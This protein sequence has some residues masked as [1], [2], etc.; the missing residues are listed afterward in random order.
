MTNLG[1]VFFMNPAEVAASKLLPGPLADFATAAVSGFTGV[2]PVYHLATVKWDRVLV[3]LL[4]VLFLA[5]MITYSV[6][7][8]KADDGYVTGA[9]ISGLLLAG[10][11]VYGL[12][13]YDKST[14]KISAKISG[15][16]P[17]KISDNAPFYRPGMTNNGGYSMEAARARAAAAK[18]Q[19]QAAY[20]DNPHA[21]ELAAYG[22]KAFAQAQPAVAK[23]AAAMQ[24]G[25]KEGLNAYSTAV[26]QTGGIRN[27]F[28]MA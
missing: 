27:P 26:N 5:L 9:V 11:I 8:A 6:K 15:K 16:N 2:S 17:A 12:Y 14:G 7:A 10:V 20:A 1:S 24:T 23:H 21:Q 28:F 25:V 3:L 19:A 4:F 18:D 22:K 13:D